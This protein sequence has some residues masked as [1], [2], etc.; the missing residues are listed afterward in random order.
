MIEEREIWGCAHVTIERFGD[1]ASFH[2]PQRADELFSAE[3]IE[4]LRIWLRILAA[5]RSLE[6]A[7]PPSNMLSCTQ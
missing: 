1:A 2:A 4:G 7:E 6:A 3:D 5:I